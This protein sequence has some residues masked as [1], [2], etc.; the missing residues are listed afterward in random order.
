MAMARLKTWL[1]V[2]RLLLR[3]FVCRLSLGPTS[4]SVLFLFFFVQST[5]PAILLPPAMS[6][7]PIATHRRRLVLRFAPDARRTLEEQLLAIQ[8]HLQLAHRMLRRLQRVRAQVIST[9]WPDTPAPRTP[10][11]TADWLEVAVGRF[12]A[13]KASSA[14]AGARRA[15]EFVRAWYPGLDLS[16]LAMFRQEAHEELVAVR[17]AIIHRATTITEY[18]DTSVFIPDL[19][20]DD[21]K[22]SAD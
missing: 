19:N 1:T 15:L 16:Q 11:R 20:D 22:L 9:L 21:A 18:T 10:S 3:P 5:S 13:W 6:S 2:S 8:A 4:D 14:R 17:L 7:R 12:E